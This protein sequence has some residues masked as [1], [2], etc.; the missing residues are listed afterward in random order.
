MPLNL[1]WAGITSVNTPW[2]SNWYRMQW[3]AGAHYSTLHGRGVPRVTGHTSL[4]S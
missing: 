1:A 4:L 3:F 2:E